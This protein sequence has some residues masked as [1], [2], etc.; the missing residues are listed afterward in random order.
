MQGNLHVRFG[1]GRMEKEPQGHLASRLPYGEGSHLDRFLQMYAV[2]KAS[3]EARRR[4]HAVA[5]LA[6]PDGS[7]RLTIRVGGGA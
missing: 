6:L 2:E 5:E 3:I 4:G 7:V 1:G